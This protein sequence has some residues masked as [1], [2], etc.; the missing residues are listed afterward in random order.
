MGKDLNSAGFE[1]DLKH[2]PFYIHHY[3]FAESRNDFSMSENRLNCLNI[4]L[5]PSISVCRWKVNSAKPAQNRKKC[6][7]STDNYRIS[8]SLK[9]ICFAPISTS[10]NVCFVKGRLKPC[11]VVSGNVGQKKRWRTAAGTHTHIHTHPS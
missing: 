7:G 5:Q 8:Q 6:N 3:V 9:E 4:Q 1:V 10:I 2:V 11:V